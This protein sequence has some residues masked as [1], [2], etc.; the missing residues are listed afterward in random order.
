MRARFARLLACLSLLVVV[1]A[2]SAAHAAAPVETRVTATATALVTIATV[3]GSLKVTGWNRPEVTVS[4]DGQAPVLTALDG[5]ARV[6]IQGGLGDATLEVHVPK[7]AHV[8]ARS[9]GAGVSVQGVDGPVQVST[10]TGNVDVTGGSGDVEVSSISGDVTLA[11][12]K[13]DVRATT[14]SG[15]LSVRCTGGGTVFAK[16]VSGALRVA[17]GV[18]TRIEGRSVSGDLDVDATPQGSGPFVLRTHSGALR[19]TLPKN[20]PV[21]VQARSFSGHVDDGGDDAGAAA[22]AVLSLAT[23]SGDIHVVRR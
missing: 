13:A 15:R 16:A 4:T 5:G 10:A 23:F 9:I 17:G 12:G 20:A 14:V 7:G 6:Q 3:G 21:A 1:L 19:V 18:M 2:T 22:G 11:L 8:E